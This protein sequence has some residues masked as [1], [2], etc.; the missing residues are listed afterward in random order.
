MRLQTFALPSVPP[1]YAGAQL[2]ARIPMA[3]YKRLGH[4][5]VDQRRGQA[6]VIAEALDEYLKRRGA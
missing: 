5:V 2:G 1:F 4:F 3:L 6:E